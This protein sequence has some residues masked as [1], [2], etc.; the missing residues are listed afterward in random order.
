MISGI[1]RYRQRS[2]SWNAT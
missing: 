2:V 1:L